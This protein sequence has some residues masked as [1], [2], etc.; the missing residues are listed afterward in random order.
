MFNRTISGLI[1]KFLFYPVPIIWVEGKDD[2]PFYEPILHRLDCRIEAAGGKDE[3][4]K[5][6][7]SIVEHEYPFVVILD[8]DYEI[9]KKMANPHKRI[10]VLNKYSIENFLFEKAL[11]QSICCKY[12]GSGGRSEEIGALFD[13]VEREIQSHLYYLVVLDIANYKQNTGLKAFPDRV[14]SILDIVKVRCLPERISTISEMLSANLDPDI[15]DEARGLVRKFLQSGRFSDLLRG[16]IIFGIIRHLIRRGVKLI[17]NNLP[18]IDNDSLLIML[19]LELW[20]ITPSVQHLNLE[21]NIRIA[22]EE[23]HQIK[24]N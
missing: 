21:T 5:I 11:V 1:N 3:C 4:K 22:V 14:D 20:K 19:S 17:T 24:S 8:G 13:E 10:L 12:E 23:A 18:N 6:A 7:N 16:H 15:I 9:L 2:F